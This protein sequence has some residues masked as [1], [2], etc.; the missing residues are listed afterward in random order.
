MSGSTES[1][2]ATAGAVTPSMMGPLRHPL[3]ARIWTASLVSN[4]GSLIQG[5][6][7]AWLMTSL[8]AS[9]DTVALVQASSS[10]PMLAFALVAGAIAD[11]Y[12][13][14]LV[15]MLAQGLMFVF[16]AAL[17]VMTWMGLITP[18]SLLVFTFLIGCGNALNSPSWQ[19]SVGEQVPRE[20]LPRA[21]ALNSMGFNLARSLGPAIGGLI[22]AAAGPFAAFLL[23]ALSY[24][25]LIGVLAGWK[26]PKGTRPLPAERLAPAVFDGLR[27]V[28]LSP[29]ISTML[30]RILAFGFSGAAIWALAPLVARTVLH[31]GPTTYGLLLGGLGV[32]AVCGALASTWLRELH[33]RETVVRAAAL[34]FALSMGVVAVSSSLLLTLVALFLG[35]VGWVL[36]TSSLNISVQIFSPGW[37]VGRSVSLFQTALFGGLA[38]GSWAWGA[39]AQ[40]WGIPF[41]IGLSAVACVG[42]VGLGLR[43][44]LPT[45]ERPDLA[46]ARG[47]GI[48]VP[49][50]PTRG[51]VVVT[52]EYRVDE[53]DGPAFV[54]AMIEKRRIRRRDGARRWSLLQ[55]LYDGEVWLERFQSPSWT[56]HLRQRNRT[57]V[58]DKHIEDKVRAFHKGDRPP[59]I[60]RFLERLPGPAREFEASRPP[61]SD[62]TLP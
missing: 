59:A 26:R 8:S 39:V 52:V 12:D 36:T 16:S 22:V 10:V 37:V 18:F 24:L 62:A 60:H 23:N 54:A 13:R 48:E 35:G 2:T 31:G 6:G 4:F 17:A 53:A 34:A 15:M 27:Y 56:E 14:R 3:F 28:V 58:S 29:V 61:A 33:S 43:W 32:G 42:T 57:T 45:R 19:A 1:T 11:I 46:P 40:T 21:I 49:V 38:I 50:E 20:D 44:P 41:A 55:D 7:A 5:V 9:A 30:V 51:V 47:G 25:G